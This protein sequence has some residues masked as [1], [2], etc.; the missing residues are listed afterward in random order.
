MRD[1]VPVGISHPPQ[2]LARRD[3]RSARRTGDTAMS[4]DHPAPVMTAEAAIAIDAMPYCLYKN[5]RRRES[6]AMSD[7]I[8]PPSVRWRR[9]RSRRGLRPV[10]GAGRRLPARQFVVESLFNLEGKSSCR[11]SA[12]AGGGIALCNSWLMLGVG[13]P[14]RSQP[15]GRRHREILDPRPRTAV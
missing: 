1:L 5:T 11:F 13:I 10:D 2:P 14:S 3:K 4:P 9:R 12:D 8:V 15:D 6:N 7:D